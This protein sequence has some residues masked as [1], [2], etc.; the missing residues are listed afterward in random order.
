MY[1]CNI[2]GKEFD[3]KY[4]LGSHKSCHNRTTRKVREDRIKIINC[5]N[6]NKEIEYDSKYTKPTYCNLQC[7]KDYLRKTKE[8]RPFC[9]Q[10][11]PRVYIDKT[12]GEIDKLKSEITKC[13]ICGKSVEDIR[14]ENNHFKSLCI[15]HDHI[16]NKFRG[17]LCLTCNSNLAWYEANRK[18][19]E[20]Y[21]DKMLT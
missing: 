15:D 3:N 18:S 5:R 4:S 16:T 13:Q 21:I 8:D 9:I 14:A 7:M 19:I 12:V 6:C 11:K 2:C 10:N 1:K 17:L 20:D